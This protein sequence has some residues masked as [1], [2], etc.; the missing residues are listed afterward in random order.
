MTTKKLVIVI[1]GILAGIVLL[2]ALFV[3]AIVGAAFYSIAHSEAATTA[4]NFLRGN[5]RLKHEIGEVED[6]GTFVT[7]NIN[8]HNFDG[9]ATLNLK[10]IGARR[11]VNATVELMYRDGHAWRVTDASY[12][13]DGGRMISL[14]D[15]YEP[16]APPQ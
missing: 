5:E 2:V 16:P 4:K 3:G 7:G 11:S 14:L 1:G 6:F 8:A 10:V 12:Q 13:G 15:T 9:A